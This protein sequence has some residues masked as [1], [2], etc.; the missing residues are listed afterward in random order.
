MERSERS[1]TEPGYRLFEFYDAPAA[2]PRL[3]GLYVNVDDIVSQQ[4]PVGSEAWSAGVIA[5]A[6]LTFALAAVVAAAFVGL[7][8]GLVNSGVLDWGAAGRSARRSFWRYCALVVI[9]V[10]P[11]TTASVILCSPGAHPSALHVLGIWTGIAAL[12]FVLSLA[13]SIVTFDNAGLVR[14]MG[15]SVTTVLKRLPEAVVVILGIGCLQYALMGPAARAAV[16]LVR[17]LDGPSRGAAVITMDLLSWSL[18]TL[19]RVWFCAAALYWWADVRS[20][21]ATTP[22]Q[23]AL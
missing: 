14:A 12:L 23:H 20:G 8:A 4:Y 19:V 3:P 1:Q 9:P 17:S 18:L 7:L 22:R 15:M 5:G 2:V 13:P 16:G 10:L 6:L 21:M 11:G